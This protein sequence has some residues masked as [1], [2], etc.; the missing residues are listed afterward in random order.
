[1]II[2]ETPKPL[3]TAMT[4]TNN[5]NGSKNK[6]IKRIYKFIFA[7]TCGILFYVK[8]DKGAFLIVK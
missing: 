6:T 1:M 3:D 8:T 4:K 5:N 2:Y 7:Y